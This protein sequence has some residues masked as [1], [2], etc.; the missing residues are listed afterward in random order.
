MCSFSHLLVI[1]ALWKFAIHKEKSKT[2]ELMISEILVF[3][4]VGCMYFLLDDVSEDESFRLQY[5]W[6]VLAFL[7][8]SLL[9]HGLCFA[10]NEFIYP[11]ILYLM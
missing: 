8:L 3:A 10:Y 4:G 6:I 7:L 5:C 2:Y 9:I 1:I 11:I